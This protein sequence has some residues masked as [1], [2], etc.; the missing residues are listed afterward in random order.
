MTRILVVDDVKLFRHM[1]ASALGWLGYT[2]EEAASGN[3][4]LERIRH[5][6]PDLVLLDYHMPGMSG[7][8]VCAAI[9]SDPALHSLPV[10]MVASSARD[11]DVR[12]AVQ[13]GCDDFLTKPLDDATLVRKVE[14]LLGGAD[15]RRYPRVPASMQVSFEDFQGIFIEYAR[16]ISR[17]GVFIEMDEPLAVGARLRLTFSLPPPFDE[18]PVQAYGRVVRSETGG[19]RGPAGV[20]VSFIHVDPASTKV[21]DALVAGQQ[22]PEQEATGQFGRVSLR[23]DAD[24]DAAPAADDA[25]QTETED[26]RLRSLS[27]DCVDLRA[28]MDEMQ[29]DHL[30][31]S[32]LVA[33]AEGLCA[34]DSPAAVIAAGRDVLRDLIGAAAYGIFIGPADGGRLVAVASNGLPERLAAAMPLEGP[35]LEALE[36]RRVLLPAPPQTLGDSGLQLLAAA[37]LSAGLRPLGAIG[38]FRLFEQKPAL[39]LTDQQLLEM[40]GRHLGTTLSARVAL[41]RSG[42][43]SPADLLQAI[44][45][46]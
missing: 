41:A 37:G 44:S 20:G 21:I 6:P 11:D 15:R 26:P 27:R 46:S 3:E 43:P 4:A 13:A 5:D 18:R 10:I 14:C 1:E 25:R 40:L 19:E 28:A 8:E 16:D 33:V 22:L 45:A 35:L 38:I 24:P 39:G 9:K 31:L 12:R 30:R 23:V 17:S 2:I 32:A 36:Q 29:R 7:H 42:Q 34:A